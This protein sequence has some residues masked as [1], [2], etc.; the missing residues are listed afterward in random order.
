MNI[1]QSAQLIKDN[2][3][4]KH[5]AGSKAYGTNLPTSDTDFRGIFVGDPVNIRTPFFRIEEAKDITEEDTVI[6]EL[7]Q[8]M[9]LALDCNPNVIETLWI[10][11]SDITF[12]TLA[13]EYLRSFAPQ[14]LSSK[15][16]FTTSGYA[17]AQLKRIKGHNKWINQPQAIDAPRQCDYLSLIHNFTD[18]K[19]FKFDHIRFIDGYRLVPFSGDTYGVYEAELYSLYNKDSGNLNTEYTGESHTHKTPLFIIK[20]N[21]DEYNNTKDKWFHYWEWKKNRNVTRSALEE[22]FGYDCYSDDTEFLT[23]NGWKYFDNVLDSD[24]IAT[25]NQQTHKIEY[26]SPIERIKSNYTGNMYKLFG[27]H[28]NT[29]VSPNHWMYIRKHSRTTNVTNQNWELVRIAEMP[30]TFDTLNIIKPKINRNKLPEN[31]NLDLVSNMSMLSLMRLMGWFISDGTLK[32]S[33]PDIPSSM[34]ISQSKPQSRL[35]Q[36]LTRQ[37]NLGHLVCTSETIHNANGIANHPER[38]WNFSSNI[39]KW[40]YNYCGHKSE[41]KRIPNWVF[42]LTKREMTTLLVALL[43]G[44][45]TK[46]NH[47]HHTYVYYTKN[48]LLA[49]DVQRLS[50][51]CGYETT[52][53]GPYETP[54][55]FNPNLQM[56]QVHI[57]MRPKQFRRHVRSASIDISP[58]NNQQIVCFM[59]KNHTLVTR[60]NGNIGL[61]G[62]TKHAMHL[63]RLLRMGE[64]ALLTGELLVK[65]PDAK[66]L[67]EIRAGS[68]SY[69][70]LVNY[71]EEKD[72]YIRHILYKNTKLPKTPDLKLAAKIL[73]DVQNMVWENGK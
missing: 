7:S 30:E 72:N 47:Q 52:K 64:E 68:W 54:T 15:I 35:T 22:D 12:T 48:S 1:K 44:D 67:L 43:Q 37:I 70:D 29:Y 10:D 56:Y 20:F 2:L 39:A 17:L 26:Q 69:D 51:L 57:N 41:N 58:V 6:Y 33:S 46:K 53:W 55:E 59:V 16:A 65:R 18:E 42:S 36:N 38:R 5:Y 23:D 3:I 28:T 45:G 61:H 8:F 14:L 34:M 32:F 40:L 63:V 27:H 13:Y 4:V 49:D 73:M 71:A 50:F 9:K 25:F 66:E 60:R 21:K 24:L 31:L 19:T 11:K 62:N